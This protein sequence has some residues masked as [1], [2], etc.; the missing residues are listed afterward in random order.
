MSAVPPDYVVENWWLANHE[1]DL[2]DSQR[3]V[4][5]SLFS[6]THSVHEGRRSYAREVARD[7]ARQMEDTSVGVFYNP[8]KTVGW[9]QDVWD[10]DEW[11]TED[12]EITDE[13]KEEA[14]AEL[15]ES[16]TTQVQNFIF[17]LQQEGIIRR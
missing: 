6:S 14:R 15:I 1:L 11:V 12:V 5:V 17:W 3:R 8:F 13:T 7:F 9:A 10:G 4:A 2:F 16:I